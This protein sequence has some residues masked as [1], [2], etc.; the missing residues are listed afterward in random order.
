MPRVWR[1]GNLW[2]DRLVY[3]YPRHWIQARSPSEFLWVTSGTGD[4]E[5]KAKASLPSF[6]PPGGAGAQSINGGSWDETVLN[7]SDNLSVPN[8]EPDSRPGSLTKVPG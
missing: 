3:L 8:T 2:K 1:N 7:G 4:R 6:L 5:E